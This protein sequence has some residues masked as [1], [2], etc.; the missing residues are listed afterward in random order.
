MTE[1]ERAIKETTEAMIKDLE[2][3]KAAFII[4][5]DKKIESLEIKGDK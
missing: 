5:M 4:K 1:Y 3:K 2:D